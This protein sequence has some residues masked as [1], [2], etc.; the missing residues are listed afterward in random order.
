MILRIRYIIQIS[1]LKTGRFNLMYARVFDGFDY[2]SLRCLDLTIF[3]LMRIG[4][5]DSLLLA[6]Y[7]SAHERT[8]QD[9]NEIFDLGIKY[10]DKIQ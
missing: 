6:C 8:R 2:K 4:N 9:G 3:M 7:T 10:Y 1:K 5:T